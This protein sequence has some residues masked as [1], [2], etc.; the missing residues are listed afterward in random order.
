MQEHRHA[1]INLLR[2]DVKGT[3]WDVFRQWVDTPES[4][5][6][7][8]AIKSMIVEIHLLSCEDSCSVP[9][10]PLSLACCQHSHWNYIQQVMDRLRILNDV[11]RRGKFQIFSVERNWRRPQ[12]ILTIPEFVLQDAL[13]TDGP[14][15]SLWETFLGRDITASWEIGMKRVE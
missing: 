2:L 8:G 1:N 5:L 15:S 13:G 7:S 12:P 11:I 6:D 14:V 9:P 3:G 4:I 10:N